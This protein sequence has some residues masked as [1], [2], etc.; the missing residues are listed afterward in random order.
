[1]ALFP[2]TILI[3]PIG[4]HLFH[5]HSRPVYSILRSLPYLPSW[6]SGLRITRNWYMPE[7][8]WSTGLILTTFFT[9]YCVLVCYELVNLFRLL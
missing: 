3:R 2:F 5:P 6:L 7:I 8:F 9:G 1:M 4:L